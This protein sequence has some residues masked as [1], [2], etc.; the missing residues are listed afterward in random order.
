MNR[1]DQQVVHAV[2]WTALTSLV[3][4]GR[5]ATQAAV[6]PTHEAVSIPAPAHVVADAREVPASLELNGT[7]MADEESHVSPL[8]PGRVVEVMVER[9]SVVAEGD[10]LVRLRDTDYRLQLA[11][12]RAQLDQARARLGIAE[13]AAPPAP[14]ATPDVQAARAQMELND[15]SL[16]RAEGLAERGVFTQSQLDE[17]RA[18]AASSRAAYATALQNTRASI[19]ALSSAST[20][21]RQASTSVSE[22]VI[23][24]PFA[25]EIADRAVAP[26]EYVTAASHLVTLV[27][28]DPLRIEVHIPQE[29]LFA[30]YE[31]QAVEVRVDAAPGHVFPATI[32]YISASVDATSRGLAVEAVVPNSDEHLRLRPGMFASARILLGTTATMA[33]VP[34]SAVLTQAGVSRVF[35][36]RDGSIVE[37]V[38]SIASRESGTV[39][40]S[41]G[42][43]PGDV[44]A[45]ENLE[46]LADGMLISN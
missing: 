26:G 21:L 12:A 29:Q 44:V 31:G 45:T 5:G 22:S 27:R 17:A 20:T 35:I 43:S 1:R 40:I 41:R 42:V 32:R 10:P 24:A 16:T 4:C 7:L 30:V 2:V 19:A 18:R 13:G 25:G 37:S 38:V 23:R 11:G 15:G 8:V 14:E 36:L 34:G 6:T 39:T 46:G 33:T 3:G 9:G 28:T